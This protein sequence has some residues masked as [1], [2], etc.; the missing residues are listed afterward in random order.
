MAE[1][2]VYGYY[3][4]DKMPKIQDDGKM[5]GTKAAISAFEAGVSTFLKGNT[6]LPAVALRLAV[7]GDQAT[8]VSTTTIKVINND[9]ETFSIENY[10]EGTKYSL[11]ELVSGG[12][13]TI[14]AASM[15][16][17]PVS[18]IGVVGIG[19]INSVAF[20][21]VEGATE[22]W[23]DVGD[24]VNLR[25]YDNDG[26]HV[27]GF[28]YPDG[29]D[30]TEKEKENAVVHFIGLPED[31]ENKGEIKEGGKIVFEGTFFDDEYHVY[32][33]NSFADRLVKLSSKDN[34]N[35]WLTVGDKKNLESHAF[36]GDDH[37]FFF[38]ENEVELDI[39]VII[40]GK[41][42]II[43]ITRIYNDQALEKNLILGDD[44]FEFF[45]TKS[46]V[47]PSN[48][49]APATLKSGWGEELAIGTE[50][51]DHID[52]GTDDDIVVS[53]GGN[54][55]VMASG[56]DNLIDTGDGD[57]VVKTMSGDDTIA[58]GRGNDSVDGGEGVD[59][60]QYTDNKYTE[61]Q[62]EAYI[63]NTYGSKGF[64]TDFGNPDAVFPREPINSVFDSKIVDL[65]KGVAIC[66]RLD[67][68]VH[69]GSLTIPTPS[70][71][72][73]ISWR[74]G[75]IISSTYN[76]KVTSTNIKNIFL[77]VY[78]RRIVHGAF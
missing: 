32:N 17:G 13:M 36:K 41:E 4:V 31:D 63:A 18:V 57:D 29:L 35:D 76:H 69:Y 42:Q 71:K 19:A 3:P 45:D 55:T 56:G 8:G 68:R 48:P 25:F 77:R 78:N 12:A 23:Y 74:I 22:K 72:V 6:S 62:Y 50:H 40:G 52:I 10:A 26:K 51:D 2:K 53:K 60:I 28:F 1:P 11:A 5:V 49:D 16:G 59:T 15:A 67:E 21:A 46:L 37:Y 27:S 73:S 14:A 7:I 38:K 30:N 9:D 33:G 39:P 61:A 24:Q 64:G 43:P 20:S 58:P 70:D 66:S 54:D 47:I 75:K 44:S 34:I 65:E